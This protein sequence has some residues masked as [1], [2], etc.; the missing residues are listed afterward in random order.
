ITSPTVSLS[1]NQYRAVFTNTCNGTQTANS[2][3]ATLTVNPKILTITGATAQNKIYNAT[4]AATVD[5]SGA[6]LVGVIGSDSVSINS[7]SYSANFNTKDVGNIKPV[8]VTGVTLSGAQAGNYTV[9]QP[10]GLSANIT[11]KSL[12]VS[13]L[14]AS[15]KVYDATTTAT[16]TGTATLQTAEA[17]GAGTTSDGKPYTG[18]RVTVGGTSS[19]KF[20][21]KDVANG[22]A[23]TVSGN[24]ISGAQSAN[25]SLSQQTGLRA[26][27]TPKAL[28]VSG[29]SASNKVYDATTTATLTGTAA[30]QS[31]EAPGAGTTSDGKPY[32]GDT[33]TVGGTP[34][35]TFASKDVANG[36]AVTVSGNTISGAQSAN[37][38]LSQQTGLTAD[39]TSKALTVSGLTA[40][41]RPYDGTTAA[42][43]SGT[44]A[45]QT[46]EASGSGTT[47]DGKPYT[48]DAVSVSGT[49]SATF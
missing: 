43:L 3:A 24:T 35:G 26:N 33:V 45:L 20:A 47:S 7:S 1:G 42:T 40:N 28:A 41:S 21:S 46:S 30:L 31:A 18:R 17:P 6:S 5:F 13:G 36:I 27:I 10:S 12:T 15:N 19:A 23:V 39:I 37:Y 29:L 32:T 16:L 9:S 38:T 34:S 4:T 48:G 8:T 44:A 25:Y 2:N 22:I 14:S 49:P 11:P